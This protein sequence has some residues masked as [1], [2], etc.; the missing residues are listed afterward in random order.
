MVRGIIALTPSC[1]L[2]LER[3]FEGDV[4]RL[5]F[6]V[7]SRVGGVAFGRDASGLENQRL[8]FFARWCT[9]LPWLRLRARCFLPS[10]VPP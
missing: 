4:L 7:D 5:Q 2:R 6:D 10:S 8:E 1:E 9:V 3:F